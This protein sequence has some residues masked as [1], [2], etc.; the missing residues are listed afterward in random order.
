[1]SS[2]TRQKATDSATREK[3]LLARLADAGEEALHKLTELPGGQRALNAMNELRDRVDDLARKV[4]GVD[5]LEERVTK[6]EKE[7]ASLKKAKASSGG[8]TASR[9]SASPS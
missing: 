3:D 5:A 7:V 4:R 9:K 8:S 6:L 1:M 2:T